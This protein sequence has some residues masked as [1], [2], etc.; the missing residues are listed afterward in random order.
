MLHA[1]EQNHQVTPEQVDI[2]RA[3]RDLR[4]DVAVTLLFVPFYVLAAIVACR[5]VFRRFSP[6][7]RAARRVGL[8]TVSLAVS[9]RAFRYFAC[10]VRCGRRFG[11]ATGMSAPAFGPPPPPM[12]PG[13]FDEQLIVAIVLFWLTALA[14]HRLASAGSSHEN[15]RPP[16]GLL[17]SAG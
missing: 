12:G 5:W 2:A 8:A 16:S 7:E 13:M 17:R 14:Y 6:E 9:L 15:P 4:F 10:G 1:V 3:Q 11:L